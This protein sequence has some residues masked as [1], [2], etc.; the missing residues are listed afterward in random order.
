MTDVTFSPTPEGPPSHDESETKAPLSTLAAD[1]IHDG[2]KLVRK[3]VQLLRHNVTKE[4]Q[5][6]AQAVQRAGAGIYLTLLGV[7]ALAVSVAYLLIEVAGLPTWGSFLIVGGI[8]S[9]VGLSLY[10]WN[11]S[12][13]K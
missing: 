1:L 11:D 13:S 10:Y 4:L 12:P 5:E 2:Q 3:E 8:M 9:V 7:T 6:M